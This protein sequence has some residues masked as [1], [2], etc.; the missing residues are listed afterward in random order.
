MHKQTVLLTGAS[1]EVGIETFKELLRRR[2]RY[3]IRILSLDRKVEQQLFKPY[4]DQVDIIW[5]DL[6]NPEDV[7][8][9]VDG[10]DAVIHAAAVIPPDADHHP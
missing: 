5:G 8:K 1:G 3:D 10:A 2:E 6:R 9:A 7:K 4:R